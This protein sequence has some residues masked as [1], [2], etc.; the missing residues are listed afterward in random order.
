MNAPLTFE[1]AIRNRVSLIIAIAGASGSGKTLSALKIARGLAGG[2]DNKIAFV[3]TEAGRALHYACARDEKPGPD[4]FAFRHR[5]LRAPF[6][7]EAYAELIKAADAGDHEVVVVD[8]M[9][10]E[11]AGDGG[12]QDMHDQ[13][14]AAAVEKARAEAAERKW[15]FDELKAWDKASLSCWNEPKTRHKRFVTRLLQCR[16]HL[17]ICLRADE[18]IRIET[19]TEKGDNGKEYKKTVIVQPK[20]MEPKDRWVPICEKRFMYEMTLSLVLTPTA[21]GIPL[22]IKL[23]AQHRHAVPLNEQ[24]SEET[25]RQLA[26]WARGTVGTSAVATAGPSSPAPTMTKGGDGSDSKTLEEHAR[27]LAS[28]ALKGR[29]ELERAFKA[30]PAVVQEDLRPELERHWKTAKK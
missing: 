5:E 9:S 4:H 25:G 26:Q 14:V 16:A 23:Q 21:P 15:R 19:V 2:D 27:D 22:P 24:L 3:D 28:A 10:H 6:T 13:M 8:S 7:P 12:L 29:P 1:P 18:K 11:W 17:V 30:M 20:D